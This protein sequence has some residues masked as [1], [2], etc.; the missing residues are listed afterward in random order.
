MA[1]DY[2]NDRK[3]LTPVPNKGHDKA[4]HHSNHHGPVVKYLPVEKG[5]EV[6]GVEDGGSS[7]IRHISRLQSFSDAMPAQSADVPMA[8][9]ASMGMEYCTQAIP[10]DWFFPSV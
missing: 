2:S 9:S 8:L 3:S 10:L 4:T 7:S 6:W 5:W 1:C